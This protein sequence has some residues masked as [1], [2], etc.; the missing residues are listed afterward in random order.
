[1][2]KVKNVEDL[3]DELE[4]Q[5][6]SS[7]NVL[8][9]SQSSKLDNEDR[10]FGKDS[11]SEVITDYSKL[12]SGQYNQTKKYIDNYESKEYKEYLLKLESYFIELGKK[13]NKSQFNFFIKK[14]G[15]YVKK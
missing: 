10:L 6:N 12:P 9:I 13:K 15:H 8:N 7:S 14:D 5:H 11:V 1:M 2:K 4:N 3:N